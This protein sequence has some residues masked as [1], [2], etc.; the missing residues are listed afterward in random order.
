MKKIIILVL[1][2]ALIP[3][4]CLAGVNKDTFKR[5][6]KYNTSGMVYLFIHDAP[7]YYWI[8][9][10]T[11]FHS[12]NPYMILELID[13]K[14]AGLV[15]KGKFGEIHICA[16]IEKSYVRIDYGSHFV[17]CKL[18]VYQIGQNYILFTFKGVMP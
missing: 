3:S 14:K 6:V 7:T 1:I 11:E 16:P 12:D 13:G 17:F 9:K 15:N 10:H 8:L 2:L 18:Q 4:V 5:P